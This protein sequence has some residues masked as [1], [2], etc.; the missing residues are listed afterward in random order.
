ML[1]I[2]FFAAL[3][4]SVAQCDSLNLPNYYFRFDVLRSF[5]FCFVF[6]FILFYFDHG[7]TCLLAYKGLRITVAKD[8]N[9]QMPIA[10]LIL[11]LPRFKFYS[12]K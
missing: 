6:Y 12:S 11:Y 1:T 5:L 4:Q 2:N 10:T 3:M 7:K 9:T 8:L